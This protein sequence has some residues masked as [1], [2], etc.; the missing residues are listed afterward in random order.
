MPKLRL[1]QIGLVLLR[2]MIH[3]GSNARY[4]EG[5]TPGIQLV[6]TEAEV[7]LGLVQGGG[8][9]ISVEERRIVL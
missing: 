6:H 8:T 1:H 3:E 7:L 2:Q 5:T 9:D 4:E